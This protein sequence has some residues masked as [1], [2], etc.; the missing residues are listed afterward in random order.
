MM[1]PLFLL[2]NSNGIGRLELPHEKKP[3]GGCSLERGPGVKVGHIRHPS[4]NVKDAF[5]YISQEFRRE[6]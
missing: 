4:R 5:I 1:T 6:F 3:V 2:N